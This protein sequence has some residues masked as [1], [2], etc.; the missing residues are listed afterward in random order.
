ML[1]QVLILIPAAGYAGQPVPEKAAAPAAAAAAASYAGLPLYF[2]RNEGQTDS[3]VKFYER[4]PRH[5]AF[6][7]STGLVLSLAGKKGTET[8][9]IAFDGAGTAPEIAAE[10]PLAARVNYFRGSD[11]AAWR[12]GIPVYRAL[13][14]RD[15]YPNVDIRYY[16]AGQRVEHDIIVK[17]GA[18]PTT[19]RFSAEGVKS[20]RV[21]DSG[22]LELALEGGVVT[23][24]RPFIYQEIDG[25]RVKVEGGYRVIEEAGDGRAV[26]GF[27]V[28]SYDRSRDLVIDPVLT[29]STY[30]GGSA[31]DFARDVAVDA[32]G[33]TYITGWTMSLDFPLAS[34]VQG[35]NRGG[36]VTGDAFVTKINPAG[37][38]VVYSTY[39]GG[40][41]DEDSISIA[42]DSAGAAYI[43][44]DTQSLDFPL[45]RAFQPFFGGGLKDG[46]VVKI[47]PAGNALVFSSYLGGTGDDKS[48]G[49]A[50][51]GTG[52]V[53]LTGWTSSL[54]FPVV[55]PVQPVMG[56]LQ[57]VFVM[58]I[59]PAGTTL[60]YSTYL[61]GTDVDSGRAITVNSAGEA[62][63]TGHTWSVNF[64]VR[65]PIQG[66]LGGIKDVVVFKLSAAGNA[67][68]FSTYLGGSGS[69]KSKGIALNSIGAIYI[70]GL[71]SS[72]DFPVLNALQG[73]LSGIQDAFLVKLAPPGRRII[74]STYIGGTDS[75]SGRDIAIDSADNTYI[76][77]HTWSFDFPLANPLQGVFGGL[78]DAYVMKIDPA[79][80]KIIYSTY[81]GGEGD[82][83]ARGIAVD[84]TGRVHVTGG[85]DSVNFPIVKPLQGINAGLND[86]FV[87]RLKDG[88]GPA[89][90]LT[91]VPDASSIA[92]GGTLGYT[93]TLVNNTAITQ[94]VSYWE[95][96]TLPGGTPYPPAGEL[97][98]PLSICVNANASKAAHLTKAIPLSAPIGAYV[99]NAFAGSPYP[100][101]SDTGGFNF[102]ITA[103][104]PLTAGRHRSWRLLENGLVR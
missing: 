43:T 28:A 8:V 66:A 99:F 54:N 73:T 52:A 44:G 26:Y 11:R 50:L 27:T 21:T 75:D 65:N 103:L 40:S 45:F 12:S 87:L 37:T 77:G 49:L 88:G 101:V 29:Y 7:T 84:G 68:V 18:D 71:T 38:A 31:G 42:V 10:E 22:E 25:K 33:A 74:F 82:D 81:I 102:S 24:K 56:G 92:A 9:S 86:A 91:L 20:I 67:L 98:G 61:G 63:V 69:E 13:R 19:I 104:G 51:D 59:N 58:K 80:S 55:N 95:N 4:G 97:F 85:T 53:Y 93:V 64:P 6:F 35:V 34:P 94:C 83:T 46:F 47:A 1:L 16:G 5:T 70:T 30:F 89:V 90:S 17:K 23:E 41:G 76:A 39:I 60:A 15:V 14:Y 32:A 78:R 57:D 36:L 72:P 48:K 3:A 96:L 2:V 62:Y 79:G 100:V